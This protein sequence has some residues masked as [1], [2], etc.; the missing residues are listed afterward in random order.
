M[1]NVPNKVLNRLKQHTGSKNPKKI[2]EHFDEDEAAESRYNPDMSDSVKLMRSG[3]GID[4]SG[5]GKIVSELKSNQK[6]KH[7]LDTLPKIDDSSAIDNE[8]FDKPKSITKKMKSITVKKPNKQPVKVVEEEEVVPYLNEGPGFT[9][10]K[11]PAS[12]D[13][14]KRLQM[15]QM[16]SGHAKDSGRGLGMFAESAMDATGL[17]GLGGLIGGIRSIT[18][19]LGKRGVSKVAEE[20]AEPIAEIVGGVSKESGPAVGNITGKTPA[21]VIKAIESALSK[22]RSQYG[23][24]AQ[25]KDGETIKVLRQQLKRLTDKLAE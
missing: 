21:T 18:S 16:D 8:S 2:I 13:A 3:T 6:S 17:K 5:L 19:G 12:G 25:G 15:H 11:K 14:Y 10:F 9:G 22:L 1:A 7:P 20:G 23:K 4:M 24:S